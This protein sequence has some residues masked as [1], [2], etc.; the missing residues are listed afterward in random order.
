[1]IYSLILACHSK[2]IVPDPL[3]LAEA[4]SEL[5][6][7]AFTLAYANDLWREVASTASAENF[8]RIVVE[9]AKARELYEAGER[10][11]NIALQRGKSRT[12]WLKRRA[13][14]SISTPRTRLLMW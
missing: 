9:R 4:R 3:S 6:S 13:S 7:G 11:M 1:M 8:A 2:A 5:P 10:I 12:R 14:F